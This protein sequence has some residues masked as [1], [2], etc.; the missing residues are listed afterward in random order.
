M[1]KVRAALKSVPAFLA[2]ITLITYGLLIPWL[3]FYWDDWN[4]AFLSHFYG[5]AELIP[6]FASWRP[7][8]GPIFAFTL[9][10]F[11]THPI[12]WQIFG[13]ALRFF[14]AFALW[15]TLKQLWPDH[16]KQVLPTVLLF[17]V[18]P[19]FSQQWV[20]LTHINQEIIPLIAYLFSFGLTIRAIRMPAH[21][22][23]STALALLLQFVGLFSTEYFLGYEMIRLIMV[24]YLVGPEKILKRIRQA[25]AIWLPYALLWIANGIWLY[26]FYRSGSYISYGLKGLNLFSDGLLQAPVLIFTEVLRTVATAVF[27][28]WTE[29][30]SLV[31]LPITSA[32]FLLA[33]G[34]LVISFALICFYRLRVE[35]KSEDFDE[36]HWAWQAMLLGLVGILVGRVPSWVAGLPFIVEFDYDRF[37]ISMMLGASLLIAGLLGF[38]I[39]SG[40]RKVFVTSLLVALAIG[41]QFLYDNAYRRDAGN[42]KNLF[43]QLSWRI[44]AM[45]PGTILLTDKIEAIPHVSDLGLTAAL[46]WV[47]APDLKSHQLPYL[48]LYADIRLDTGQLSGLEPQQKVEIPYRTASFSGSTSNMIVFYVPEAGCIKVIDPGSP[49]T[50]AKDFPAALLGAAYLSNLSRIEPSASPAVLPADLFGK[51]TGISWCYFYQKAELSRQMEDWE[52]IVWLNQEA[53]NGGYTPA[54]PL[55]RLP[56]VEAYLRTGRLDQAEQMLTE[57]VASEPD[58]TAV[59]CEFLRQTMDQA[60]PPALL[61]FAEEHLE[62]YNCSLDS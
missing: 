25:L 18:F 37:F 34:I 42:Q 38:L 23:R 3:G 40:R 55:E 43:T 41:G 22:F 51:E 26:V 11:G 4:F 50:C 54:D 44:P 17:L 30:I 56:F 24:F 53:M 27:S 36:D 5:P 8:L 35:E 10:L 58:S 1:H 57:M 28:A 61:Q 45:D 20:A 52:Q 46:N 12:T 60:A 15:W 9:S 14:L 31:H 21:R 49:L 33:F 13:L 48:L 6:A 29:P 39:K 16:K 19:G 7:F 59:V 32:S 62:Q 2:V 47:Y